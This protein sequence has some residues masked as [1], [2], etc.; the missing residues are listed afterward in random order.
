MIVSSEVNVFRSSLY[1][2]GQTFCCRTETLV[3][4]N[5][6]WFQCTRKIHERPKALQQ[7]PSLL[8]WYRCAFI[9]PSMQDGSSQIERQ[10][11]TA[12]E[13]SFNTQQHPPQQEYLCRAHQCSRRSAARHLKESLRQFSAGA[14]SA[15]ALRHSTALPQPFSFARRSFTSAITAGAKERLERLKARHEELCTQLS[16]EH[17]L[18]AQSQT[19]W[20]KCMC[21]APLCLQAT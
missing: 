17:K 14:P 20:L 12:I 4:L 1:S 11:H 16:G 15:A 19:L 6:I 2:S 10:T 7:L 21:Q 18:S 13:Q 5:S 3:D 8:D 9:D